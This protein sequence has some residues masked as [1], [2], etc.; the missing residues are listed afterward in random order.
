MNLR[1][2]FLA[3]ALLAGSVAVASAAPTPKPSAPAVAA[4]VQAPTPLQDAALGADI[5]LGG[6]MQTAANGTCHLV[7]VLPLGMQMGNRTVVWA[8]VK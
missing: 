1:P 8:C 4:P 3:L 7:F 6:F 5:T 2:G